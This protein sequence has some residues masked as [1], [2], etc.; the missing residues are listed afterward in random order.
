MEMATSLIA[1]RLLRDWSTYAAGEVAGFAPEIAE[2]LLSRGYAEPLAVPGA[3]VVEHAPAVPTTV[4]AHLRPIRR[5][6]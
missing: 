3:E 1:V 4:R 5:R 6:S 2:W